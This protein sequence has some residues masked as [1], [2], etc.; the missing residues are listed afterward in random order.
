MA[1][2]ARKQGTHPPDPT[3]MCRAHG[4]PGYLYAC[5]ALV[6]I[7]AQLDTV[8]A[9]LAKMR[10]T[11]RGEAPVADLGLTLLRVDL[12]DRRAPGDISE[13][14][15]RF[16]D[17]GDDL[18]VWPNHVLGPASHPSTIPLDAPRPAPPRQ[19]LCEEP[20]LPGT[21]VRVGVLDTGATHHSYFRGRVCFRDPE[22]L[23]LADTDGD[24]EL[25]HAAGHGTFI[26]GLVLQ[27]AP[28]ATVLARRLPTDEHDEDD[29]PHQSYISDARLA[30]AIAACPELAAVDV[31]TLS[32][33]GY[34]YRAEGLPATRRALDRCRAANGG[35]VLVAG[36]GN[37]AV[38]TRYFPA[39]FEDVI[40]VGALDE[41]ALE[42]ACFSNRGPWVDACAPG[43][44][45]HST[46]L[47]WD[48]PVAK[49]PNDIPEQCHGWKPPE[50]DRP[51]EGWAYWDGTSFAA[52]RVA[53]AIAARISAGAS[54]AEA[55]ADCLHGPGT[56]RLP[57]LGTVVNP[58]T[59]P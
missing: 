39:A 22:D 42:P 57:D 18:G 54:D 1:P 36:A 34:T 51:F 5:D 25:D 52:P 44:Y 19:G 11:V 33:G 38:G 43:V 6:A 27:H 53:A 16:R 4:D 29:A 15:D 14:V 13:V 28:R 21:G 47:R 55:V 7:T 26:A 20:G 40:G 45:A 46:F 48:G 32:L 31:L 59:Y 49:N 3:N 50:P 2:R 17:D 41:H 23:D 58:R 35:L 37:E 56:A 24:K 10:I 9:R 12:S 8:K 30:E